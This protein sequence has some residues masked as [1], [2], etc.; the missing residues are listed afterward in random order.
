MPRASKS[1]TMR[2]KNLA[3]IH[4]SKKQLGLDDDTYR[5]LLAR[6]SSSHGP[7]CRSAKDLTA[8]QVRAVLDEMRRLGAKRPGEFPGTPH[9]IDHLSAEITKIEA[10]LADMRLPWSYADAIARRM[11][12][13]ERVAWCRKREQLVGILSALHVEQEKR[14][15]LQRVEELCAKAGTTTE[16]LEED[17]ANGGL[18]LRAD[19]RRNRA[20]LKL[21]VGHL[22]G[23]EA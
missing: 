18:F 7:T 17:L 2:R 3:A 21:V 16:K 14:A 10:Q 9:N 11:Y 8:D 15:L 20:A 4:A 1:I 19:W 6:V 23:A 13:I 5:D 22:A 12:R